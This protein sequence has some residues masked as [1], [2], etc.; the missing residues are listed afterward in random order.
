[1][2]EK[3]GQRVPV[4]NR[5]FEM[6]SSRK[7]AVYAGASDCFVFI[8]LVPITMLLVSF[9]KY[10]PFSQEDVMRVFE[11]T[12]PPTA[13]RI[14]S[15]IVASLYNSG[16]TVIT[17]SVL[18]TLF[19]AS[20]AMRSLMT[21][22]DEVYSAKRRDSI[23]GFFLKAC[24]YMLEL[25]LLIVLSLSIVVYGKQIL[26]LLRGWFPADPLLAQIWSS[27][28]YLRYVLVIVL[29]VISFM[30]IYRFVPAGKRSLLRQF[31]GA[32]FSAF[33]WVVFSLLFSVYV[34]VS[35]HLGAYGYIGTVMVAMM[36]MYYCLMFLL[37]GGCIN[38]LLEE[39]R[40]ETIPDPASDPEKEPLL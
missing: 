5:L 24:L 9:I 17:I 28:R 16:S 15:V 8:S 14:I 36:W 38:V 10:L 33:A 18:L 26:L 30:L 37:I 32:L 35:N 1:M 7:V 2:T 27:A 25:V 39:R 6:I 23:V 13:Y 22:L 31:P 20:R 11:L 4:L 21:G 29:L 19:Y 40:I 3:K 34:S 12:V